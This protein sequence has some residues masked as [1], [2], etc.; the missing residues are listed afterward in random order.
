M[1]T[2]FNNKITCG[3]KTD[4]SVCPLN[5]KETC[6]AAKQ[7]CSTSESCSLEQIEKKS[8]ETKKAAKFPKKFFMKKPHITKIQIYTWIIVPLISLGGLWYHKLGLIMPVMMVFLLILSYFRGRFWCGNLCPRGAFLEIFIKPISFYG[9]IPNLF[10]AKYFRIFVVTVFMTVFTLRTKA[11]F[12]AW[13]M[14]EAL[15]K[16][17]LVFATL[18][19]VTTIIAIVLGVIYSPRAW[20]SF[21]PMGTMEK[22]IY[23]INKKVKTLSLKGAK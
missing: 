13:T 2:T 17:G 1:N 19:L 15:D 23:N 14:M 21:C 12:S 3:I 20:C 6:P 8:V 4:C 16:W 9:K 5:K 22:W 10:K 18:C 7:S 11:A